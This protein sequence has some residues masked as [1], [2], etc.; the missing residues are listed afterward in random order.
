MTQIC[1]APWLIAAIVAGAATVLP[2][3]QPRSPMTIVPVVGQW[4]HTLENG[5]AV[6]TSNP[7]Q[8]DGKSGPDLDATARSLF[9]DPRPAFAVNSA[10]AT[11]FPLAVLKGVNGF[12]EGTLQVRFKLIAGPTDQTAG[13]ALNIGPAADYLYV[14][15]NTKDG[16]VAVWEF[17]DGKRNVLA[18]GTEHAQLPLN[19]W[20]Q[21]AVQV[22]G[23]RV[24]GSV[25]GTTLKVTH[26]VA[27]SI[28]GRVGL[29]TKRD[30]T[31]AF[32]DFQA[33]RNQP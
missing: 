7:A 14:R 5:T 12:S 19:Q 11:A 16:N 15:Y 17:V 25:P 28:G 33:G 26:D 2:A 32:K 30:A 4:E 9:T 24:S 20:H 13:I 31:S 21:L 29:W 6:V 23:T 1:A 8:W 22:A 27:R 18:H 3:A 10:P